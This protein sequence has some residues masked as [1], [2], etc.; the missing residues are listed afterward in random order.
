MRCDN[1]RNGRRL[2]LLPILFLILGHPPA[3]EPSSPT[4]AS[5][6]SPV[7]AA[8]LDEW[9]RFQGDDAPE[10]RELAIYDLILTRSLAEEA[11][12]LGLDRRPEVKLELEL[13]Q[14][15]LATAA[16]RRH[17]SAS[18]EVTDE[19]VEAKYQAIKD[20]Y[21][22]PRRV[23]LR[24]LYKRYPPDA[25]DA[26]KAAVRAEM[27]R[28]RRRAQAGEDFGEL[29]QRHS[30]SQSR[31][32]KGILGNVP[33][34]TFPP[35]IDKVAMAMEPGEVSDILASADGLTL[36][37]CEKIL[38]KVVRTPE[39][40]R[41]VARRLLE[42]KA[43]DAAWDEL[44][45][46]LLAAADPH[47]RWQALDADPR[48]PDATLV[49]L[50]GDRLSLAEVERLL[51]NSRFPVEIDRIP[52]PQMQQRI[53]KYL[54][55]RRSRRE[56]ERLG[57]ADRDGQ[58]ARRLWARRKVLADRARIHLVEAELEIPTEDEIRQ[59]WQ[60]HREEFSRLPFYHLAGI[61]WPLGGDDDRAVYRQAER[62]VHQ[63]R[64]GEISFEEAAKQHSIHPSAANGGRLEPISRR[65]LPHQY[66]LKVLRAV[67][68]MEPGAMS[69]LVAEKKFLWILRLDAVEEERLMTWDEARTA[70]ENKLGTER[71]R[72]IEA[73]ILD[74]WMDRLGIEIA[75]D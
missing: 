64:T 59:Y 62:V 9:L 57:L 8:E 29:A 3:A 40:L 74:D 46:T 68:A 50:A 19:Q 60:A 38:E 26:D 42:K 43:F 41:A 45:E 34:G 55:A 56:V 14:G 5:Y 33:A 35:P 28:L 10:D 51:T 75:S 73:R 30:D 70:A 21:T 32:Q 31:F 52:R 67:L 2:G 1:H 53:E 6:R 17:L 36:L 48:D 49:E 15:A 37:Y 7:A 61:Q 72:A 39:D 71:T 69:D 47:Y 24:N 63:I 22:Q 66:G 65:L 16:L 20:T 23:R 12:R 25:T 4:V 13:K 18:L 58:G 44:Q 27:E 54:R 11:V